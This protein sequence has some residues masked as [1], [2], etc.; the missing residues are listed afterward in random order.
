VRKRKRSASLPNLYHLLLRE[1]TRAGVEY[2][3]IGGSGLNYFAKDARQILSTSD[4]DLFLKPTPDNVVRAWK[5]F[6]KGGFAVV[7]REGDHTRALRRA[8]LRIGRRLIQEGRTLIAVGPYNLMAE[9]LVA[10]S[11]FTFDQLKKH[12]VLHR[13]GKLRFGFWVGSL[14]DLLESKRV[15]DRDKDRLFLARYRRLLMGD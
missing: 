1:L 14:K 5:A 2:I 10:V 8:S 12:A 7:I 9:G 6:R 15:A 11:G 4:Y 13:D 3:V